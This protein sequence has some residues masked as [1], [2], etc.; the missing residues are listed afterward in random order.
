MTLDNIRADHFTVSSEVLKYLECTSV[1][2][3]GSAKTV[4]D[5]QFLLRVILRVV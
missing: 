4:D 3:D 5:L 1:G 2:C